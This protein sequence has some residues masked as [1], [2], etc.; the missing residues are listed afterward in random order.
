MKRDLSA[1]QMKHKPKKLYKHGGTM[2]KPLDL[3]A[4]NFDE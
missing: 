1:I 4:A 2:D 3:D